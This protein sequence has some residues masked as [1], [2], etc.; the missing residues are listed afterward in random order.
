MP[1]VILKRRKKK[2][3]LSDKIDRVVTNK[4]LTLPIFFAIIY[5]IYWIC[6]NSD[7]PDKKMAGITF[8]WVFDIIAW[9]NG[10]F[11]SMNVSV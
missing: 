8:G 2:L 5:G 10:L 11:T 3:S 9:V 1:S 6:L 4:W 7:G